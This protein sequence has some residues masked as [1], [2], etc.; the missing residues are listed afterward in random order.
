[1]LIKQKGGS[2]ELEDVSV[3]IRTAGERT[4][5]LCYH[6]VCA[7]VPPENIVVINEYPF[8]RAAQRSFEIGVELGRPWTLCLDADILLRNNAVQALRAWA[9]AAPSNVVYVQGAILDKI[10]GGP[11]RAGPYFHRTSLLPRVLEYMPAEGVSLRPDTD[12]AMRLETLGY[13][14]LQR[15]VIIAVHEFEQYYRDIY[16]KAFVHAHKHVEHVTYFEDLWHRLAACDS[17]Y[18]V[19]L[20][21]L[22]D[23]RRF[24]GTVS[25]DVRRFPRDLSSLLNK[26]GLQEKKWLAHDEITNLEVDKLMLRFGKMRVSP[27][28]S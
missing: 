6:L 13:C 4:T 24:E 2:S 20:W 12:A 5:E 27:E 14:R 15:D 1:V 18:H 23:G 17:D 22:L 8:R 3:I 26:Q 21:G 19:A 9:L 7:Q 16:R 28:S 10:F 25:H 11:R